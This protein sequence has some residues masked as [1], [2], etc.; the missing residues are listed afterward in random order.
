MPLK[1]EILLFYSLIVVSA[2]VIIAADQPG[3]TTL[4]KK[5]GTKCCKINKEGSRKKASPALNY[6]TE[7]IFRFK[8]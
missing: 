4:P 5:P 2:G 6:I 7:G 8:A 3:R 1:K